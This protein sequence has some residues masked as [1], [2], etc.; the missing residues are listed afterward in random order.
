MGRRFLTNARAANSWLPGFEPDGYESALLAPA[1]LLITPA[2]VANLHPPR[3]VAVAAAMVAHD[4]MKPASNITLTV[5]S[6]ALTV[7]SA[8][9]L[10]HS[11]LRQEAAPQSTQLE[12]EPVSLKEWPVFD[13]TQLAPPSGEE[14][15]VRVNLEA[16]KLCKRLVA[17]DKAP[18]LDERHQ[19]LTYLGWGGLA[20]I[21]EDLDKSSLRRQ[22][23]ELSDLLSEDEFASARASTPN[24]HYTDP[25]VIK[26]MW[27][28]VQRMGF[29]GGRIIEPAAG[30]GLFLAGMPVEIAQRSEITSVELDTVSGAILGKVFGDLD[31]KTHVCGIEKAKVPHG[32]FDLAI[33]NPP[34]GDYKAKETRKVGYADFSLHNYFFGKAIDL[35]R[36]GGLVVFVTSRFTQYFPIQV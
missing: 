18:S 31:V 1:Q 25:V 19:L 11:G 22:Q 27:D 6:E 24:A 16:L 7:L 15:R 35:V 34:F 23:A 12:P 3:A 21:F 13:M 5:S 2:P 30:T 8:Q 10:D 14:A 32:F 9:D 26:A 29:R 28:A 17:Q 33:S 4:A 20:R 36:P